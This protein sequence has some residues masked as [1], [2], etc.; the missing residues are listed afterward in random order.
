MIRCLPELRNLFDYI[1]TLTPTV[2]AQLLHAVQPL[3]RLRQVSA[4]RVVR[5][6]ISCLYTTM[7]LSIGDIHASTVSLNTFHPSKN[8]STEWHR[9]WNGTASQY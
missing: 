7:R 3:L 5:T 6:H 9:R 1:A 8:S 4:H 2:A